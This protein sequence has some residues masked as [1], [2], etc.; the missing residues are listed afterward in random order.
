MKVR[1]LLLFRYGLA[2]ST[3]PMQNGRHTGICMG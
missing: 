3:Y 1:Q 2:I